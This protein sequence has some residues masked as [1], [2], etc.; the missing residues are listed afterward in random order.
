[1]PRT[2]PH[3]VRYADV[4]ADVIAEVTRQAEAHERA[5]VDPARILVDPTHD[6]GKNTFHGLELLRRLDE[7]VALGRP[8]LM[9]LSNKDFVGETLGTT[10]VDRAARG[11]A[12]RDRGGRLVGRG[13]VP[14][15][16]GRRHPPRGRHGLG[17]P[18]RH[19][20]G[21]HRPGAGVSDRRSVSRRGLVRATDVGAPAVGRRRT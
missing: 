9:A 3:R 19:A 15:P 14:R 1:M 21:A 13:D 8:V 5:G 7:L 18:R 11:H 2:R 10:E 6:F 16:R 12:R 4:V 17:H 20:P